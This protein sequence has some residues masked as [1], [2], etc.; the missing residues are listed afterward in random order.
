[1]STCKFWDIER[2]EEG[3][4]PSLKDVPWKLCIFLLSCPVDLNLVKY[5]ADWGML[6][7]SCVALSP[8]TKLII[9]SLCEKVRIA[10]PGMSAKTI[11]IFIQARNNRK[12]GHLTPSI[13]VMLN[14]CFY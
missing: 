6:P 8:G 12:Q 5:K 2:D 3:E 10:T 4:W 7:L 11:L 13:S 9:P 1:M 14:K